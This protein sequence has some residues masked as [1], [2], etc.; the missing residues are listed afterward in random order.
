MKT[1]H[2][3]ALET[4]PRVALAL[5]AQSGNVL[6]P[7]HRFLDQSIR[8]AKERQVRCKLPWEPVRDVSVLTLTSCDTRV[9]LRRPPLRWCIVDWP[10]DTPFDLTKALMVVSREAVLRVLSA[11]YTA[12]GLRIEPE[13]A[14]EAGDVVFWCGRQCKVEPESPV[15]APLTLATVEGRPLTIRGEVVDEDGAWLAVLDGAFEG[16][17]LLADGLPVACSVL[18]PLL[19]VRRLFD[20]E[21]RTFE[22]TDGLVKV[23]ELPAEGP[24]RSDTGVRFTWKT[25]GRGG[26]AGRWVQ[27][28]ALRD[29]A[30]ALVDPRAAFC[31]DE[32]K[33]VWTQPRYAADATIKVHRV[34]REQYQLQLDRLPPAETLLHLPLDLRNLQL[35][36]RAL[37]QLAESPLP[38][39]R[40]LLRL[41]EDPSKVRWPV[42]VPEQPA[43]WYSLIDE[44]RSGTDEQRRFVAKALGTP[45]FAV[46]EGP[47]G[48][49]KTTAICELIQQ[50][51]ARGQRVLL[52]ASTHAA[53]DNVLERLATDDSPVDAVRVGR[54]ERVDE[55]VQGCQLD[56][57]VDALLEAWRTARLFVGC[58]DAELRAMAERTVVMAA[59]LTCGTTM[60]ILGH[61]LFQ[62]LDF[63][64]H[65][66]EQPVATSAPW[67]VLIVDEASK[68][69]TQEF[70]VPALLARRHVIVGDVRQLPPFSERAEITANLRSLV[71][72]KGRELFSHD[73]QRAMLLLF[74]LRRR[75]A[76]DAGLRWLVAEP[77]GVIE[78]IA[79]ELDTETSVSLSAVRLVARTSGRSKHVV[80]VTVADALA[81]ASP[82]L[83][84]AA[85][86]LVL[87]ADDQ[88]AVV[89]S[90]LPADLVPLRELTTGPTRLVER[91]PWLFRHAS[92]AGTRRPLRSAY[93][94]RRDQIASAQEAERHEQRWLADATHADEMAWRIT[95]IHELRW[96][97]DGR[98]RSRLREDLARL[99]PRSVDI[100]DAVGEI[101]DIS[102]PSIL[103]VVQEGTGAER[104]ERRSAL[105]DGLSQSQ[106]G[107][108]SSRFERLSYQHRMHP[109]ISSFARNNFYDGAALRDAN[110]IAQRDARIAWDY[111]AFAQRRVWIDVFG[112]EQ[113]G[114][115]ADEVR[116]VRS[117]L[118]D[119]ARWVEGRP[120][121]PARR[122]E[123][124]CLAFYVAQEKAL[125]A[126]LREL[127]G[128]NRAT[129]F[130]W[131]GLDIVCGTVD[132]FQGR[133]ADLV[134]LSLRNTARVGFLDSPNRL[135]VA[136]TRAR[137]QLVVVGRADYFSGCRTGELEAL[138]GQTALEPGRRWTGGRR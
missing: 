12:G 24:L 109:D 38:H 101:E 32:V 138:A 100:D 48:S 84:L 87:V 31:E 64:G 57:K 49:G 129:R 62:D 27:L 50:L 98:E 80:E 54:L 125:S 43:H 83:H 106:T 86:D 55:A 73:H 1:L 93:R 26:R 111:P 69:L 9:R 21:A 110:T 41:C 37:R 22:L 17:E 136:V 61:P 108:F 134:L 65:P 99:T 94:E 72:A 95:R 122:W 66:A 58:G 23:D 68:T 36:R 51:V 8:A 46:L 133:E 113:H 131:S 117:V 40:S 7:F 63:R 42:A 35:Q 103:E 20:A 2:F 112:Q 18:S 137:Q 120:P 92:W 10:V 78:W 11:E 124:A 115:N 88:L 128:D 45:D 102:L 96:S 33:V 13:Q 52:C 121:P 29:D 44:S 67:D 14:L 114:E 127:T 104:A 34:D 85:A 5:M 19:G 47:P 71:D 91:D 97:R 70:L 119:F 107:M 74:R 59:N 90:R 4:S 16:D 132:R 3:H 135:N 77:P 56:R 116:A 79:R 130:R 89:S 82:A 25:Q 105:T 30:D 6:R 126:M 60:G 28:L 76:R 75:A 123:V 81:G 118:V 39:H 15:A 53:I